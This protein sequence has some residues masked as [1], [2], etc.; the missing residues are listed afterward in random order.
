[1][2]LP[3]LQVAMEVIEQAAPD[4][5]VELG[6]REDKIG[7][8]LMKLF[9]WALGRCP[10]DR[11]PSVCDVVRGPS[12][13]KLVAAAA[14]WDGDPEAF[15]DALARV[16]P[17]PLIERTPE[18]IRVCGLNRY[19]AAWLKNQ[20]EEVA[21]HWRKVLAEKRQ[22]PAPPE[23]APEPE[24]SRNGTGAKPKRNRSGTGAP[25]AD[26]DADANAERI[27]NHHHPQ[28]PSTKTDDV[29]PV[30]EVVGEEVVS[31]F[32]AVWADAGG[33]RKDESDAEI[34]A[35]LTR[36]KARHGDWFKPL[37]SDAMELFFE[38]KTLRRHSL[39]NFMNPEIGDVRCDQAA[40]SV[41]RERLKARR[42]L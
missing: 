30:V 29:P 21:A 39:E 13:V 17:D 12:A 41:N 20:K 5:A 16:A 22:E 37:V 10:D 3:F 14:G 2:R 32:L 31:E 24:R 4:I 42:F 7:W 25:D 38:D 9:R 28:T 1:M 40:V 18:G 6:C 23:S 15:V 8:G 19:D 11:P 34:A 27:R 36:I 33:L 26:A 35:F